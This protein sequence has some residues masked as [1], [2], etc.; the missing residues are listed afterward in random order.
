MCSS[1]VLGPY[2]EH[3]VS[4]LKGDQNRYGTVRLFDTLLTVEKQKMHTVPNH[5][6]LNYTAQWKQGFRV[7]VEATDSDL[8]RPDC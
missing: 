2:W 7:I 3:L 6:K 8:Q 5:T 4:Q 1:S